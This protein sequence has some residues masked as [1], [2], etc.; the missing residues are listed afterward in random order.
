MNPAQLFKKLLKDCRSQ[1]PNQRHLSDSDITGILLEKLSKS[2]PD[3][4]QKA[5]TDSSGKTI[6]HMTRP[7]WLPKSG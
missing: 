3:R 6:W 4:V 7:P 5:G 2:N 1:N